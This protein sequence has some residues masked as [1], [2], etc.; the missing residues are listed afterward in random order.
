M[1]AAKGH[2]RR[3]EDAGRRRIPWT[4]T[5][6]LEVIQRHR[7]P[8]RID[9]NSVYHWLQCEPRAKLCRGVPMEDYRL[10]VT[11]DAIADHFQHAIATIDR[12]LAH[13]IVNADENRAGRHAQTCFVR[14]SRHAAEVYQVLDLASLG[15]LNGRAA[16]GQ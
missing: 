4:T 2:V 10:A 11:P 13:F 14:E 6:I 16:I 15:V 1:N 5:E 9:K 8:E 7:S 12:F 3:I